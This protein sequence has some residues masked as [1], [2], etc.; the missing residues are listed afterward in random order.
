MTMNTMTTVN[1]IRTMIIT[2]IFGAVT[3]SGAILPAAADSFDAPRATVKYAD[4]SIST[5]QGAA[6]LYARIRAAAY[7]VCSEFDSYH[8]IGALVERERC[9]NAAIDAAV[10]KVNSPALSAVYAS[11]TGRD[12]PARLASTS[13]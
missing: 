5:P 1:R 10:T 3:T 11:K 2:A 12:T 6:A 13:K 9:V 7:N 4:L 8:N